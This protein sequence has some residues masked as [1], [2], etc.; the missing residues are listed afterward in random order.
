MSIILRQLLC[1]LMRRNRL[2]IHS[3]SMCI[4]LNAPLLGALEMTIMENVFRRMQ[5]MCQRVFICPTTEIC[6]TGK[7]QVFIYRKQKTECNQSI[8]LFSLVSHQFCSKHH[9]CKTFIVEGKLFDKLFN[10]P[11]SLLL[12]IPLGKL[13]ETFNYAVVAV[14]V[15]WVAWHGNCIG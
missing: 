5:S 11:Y 6:R 3:Y 13:V 15:H 2:C 1:K 4:C 10:S 14:Q 9:I 7:K 12:H 8:T